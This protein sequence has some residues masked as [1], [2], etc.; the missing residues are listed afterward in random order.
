MEVAVNYRLSDEH[1]NVESEGEAKSV[2]DEKYLTLVVE[3]GEPMLFTYTDIAGIHEHDYEIDLL[4]TSR[5]TLSLSRMGYQYEDFLFEL[6]KLRN[7]LLLK[8][9]LMEETLVQ[10]A[11]EAHFNW[12]DQNG[13]LNQTG[14]CEV[15]L[16]ETA[17]VI[18]PQKGEPIR[19][20]YCYISQVNKVDYNLVV[21]NEFGEKF[22]FSKV[23]EKFDSLAKA[24]SDAFNRMMLRSQET[25]KEMIPE[26]D[27]VTV[28]K[29][30][31]FI[32]D[33]RAARR[34]DIESLSPDFWRRLTKR[35]KEAG[36]SSEYDFL[37]SIALTDQVCVGVKRGLMGDLTGSYIWLLFPLRDA[38]TAS[39]SNAVALEAFSASQDNETETVSTEENA[40]QR[41]TTNGE[42]AASGKATYLFRIQ[43]KPNYALANEEEMTSEL[44]NFIK[45]INLCMIDIN[46]RREPIFL[47]DDEL[48]NPQYAQYRFAVAKIPS[49][50]TLRN[51]FIG[52]VIHSSFDHWRSDITNLLES[53]SKANTTMKNG[54]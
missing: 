40:D 43:P 49:L 7:E 38:K 24:L 50:R 32:K 11:F 53:T 37:N 21:T 29:L 35:I 44:E 1:A 20:A 22:E 23:G 17:L 18:L 36:M 39:L 46:F 47:S 14:N 13:Q 31:V 2:L 16:Y 42:T 48:D 5:Q 51:L 9:L 15:R 28:K 52:R 25:V 27:P 41:G 10:A 26:A 45:T 30:A 4:L 54:R 6:Y 3:F 33:G 19:A 34:K 12:L 8:C